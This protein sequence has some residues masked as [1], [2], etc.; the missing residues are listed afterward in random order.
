[1]SDNAANSN[2]GARWKLTLTY[3]EFGAVA[4][5][6]LFIEELEEI[7]DIVERG[8]NWQTLKSASFELNRT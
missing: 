2:P 7:H 8:P 1:M 3:E 5:R 6:E 4:T